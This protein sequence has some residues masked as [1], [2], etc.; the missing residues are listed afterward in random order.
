[1]YMCAASMQLGDLF[2]IQSA[3]LS[4]GVDGF[5]Q[6]PSK[7]DEYPWQDLL[8]LLYVTVESWGYPTYCLK[9]TTCLFGRFSFQRVKIKL[10]YGPKPVG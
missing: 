8:R 7:I 9:D 2:L 6:S 5:G 1:M 10:R 3:L 4:G